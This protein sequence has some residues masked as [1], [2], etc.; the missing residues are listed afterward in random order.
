MAVAAG[1][2]FRDY[3]AFAHLPV[4]GTHGSKYGGTLLYSSI[5]NELRDQSYCAFDLNGANSP[6]RAYF[7]HSIG[8]DA[9]LHF[10]VIWSRP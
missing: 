4:V 2:V 1:L 7:K 10:H 5:I 9:T 6:T 8:G 3:K